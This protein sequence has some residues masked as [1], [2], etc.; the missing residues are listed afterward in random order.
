[1]SNT[2][3]DSSPASP[4]EHQAPSP[5]APRILVVDD[6]AEVLEL[7]RRILTHHDTYS[8]S[9]FE[10]LETSLFG[11]ASGGI[12]EPTFDAD[13]FSDGRVAVEAARQ[14][15]EQGRPYAVAF[16]DIRMPG[17]WDSLQTIEAL[18][19]IDSDIHAVIWTAFND[20]SWREINDRLCHSDQLLIMRKPF[21]K[22]E[23]LQ[24]AWAMSNK[25]KLQR[26]RILRQTELECKVNER[27]RELQQALGE[28]R[29]QATHDA[30]TGLANRALLMDRLGHSIAYAKRYE[31]HFVL[32]CL[33]V[34]RF[35]WINDSFG[36]DAGDVVLKTIAERL[37]VCM[38]DAD[39]IARIGGDEFVIILDNSAID[40]AIGTLTRIA[41]QVSHP[42]TVGGHQVTVTCSIGCSTFP[43]DGDNADTLLRFADAAMYRAKETGRNHI[44]IYNAALSTRIN[45]RVKLSSELKRAIERDQLSLH[46]QPQ[47]DLVSSRIVGVEALL[48]WRHPQMGDISPAFF[49]PIAEET[50][51]ISVIGEWVLREACLQGMR[52]DKA[53]VP[54]VSIAVNVSAKQITN[55]IFSTVVATCLDR[56]QFDPSRL[57]LE[58]TETAA[59]EDPAQSVP[60]MHELK[61]MGVSLSIDD[62]GT[63]YSNMHY[64]K[65]FP[66][67]KLKLDG[68][69]VR[70]ITT[71][72]GCF[73]IADAIIAMS[74]RLG[75]KVIAEFVETEGQLT[76]LAKRC[77]DQAQGYFFSRPLPPDECAKL[78]QLSAMPMPASLTTQKMVKILLTL[79]DDVNITAALRRELKNEGYQI[80]CAN[81]VEDAY[82]MLARHPVGVILSDQRMPSSSGDEFLSNVK[83]MYPNTIRLM[84]SACAD[85]TSVSRAIN[86]GAVF[87]YLTK[88][89]NKEELRSIVAEAFLAHEKLL[90]A[91]NASSS[92]AP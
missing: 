19:S 4:S 90:L 51:L 36:H 69:F 73:A 47:I 37:I 8:S 66:V 6:N 13:L 74:H 77:C 14:A 63:G 84:L 75:L 61:A 89:W 91:P 88:P 31:M 12:N 82:E 38:R 86:R 24:L 56:T 25:W 85:F 70:E 65:R 68:S 50:G 17:S 7:F 87:K 52:W 18:W 5:P 79:D 60:L 44:Q 22:I 10:A 72:P 83:R 46:Y 55:P 29:H 28:I 34:D 30:L 1:M 62:F 39:T 76:C 43:E 53:K 26:E 27:T 20:Y 33:G 42:V 40:D 16:V 21:E 3:T 11:D 92:D 71:D 81:D 57:E 48:R 41:E 54:P 35:K 15:T 80:L 2:H 58:L 67:D 49:I 23:V 59:M 45:E 64:L 9:A 32:A 78:L